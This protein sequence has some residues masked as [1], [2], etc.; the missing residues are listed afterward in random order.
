MFGSARLARSHVT[1]C[2][3]CIVLSAGLFSGDVK[4]NHVSLLLLHIAYGFTYLKAN[5]LNALFFFY[6]VEG[7]EIRDKHLHTQ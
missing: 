5:N 1:L 6:Y 2:I 3:E 7:K 4:I